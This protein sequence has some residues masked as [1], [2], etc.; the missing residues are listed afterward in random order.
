MGPGPGVGS[1]LELTTRGPSSHH[2]SLLEFSHVAVQRARRR[3][4][5]GGPLHR[6]VALLRQRLCMLLHLQRDAGSRV[7]LGAAPK[8]R[9]TGAFIDLT[10]HGPWSVRPHRLPN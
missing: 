6:L 3:L 2:Q 4:S 8:H 1:G 9:A 10:W 7:S 5:R